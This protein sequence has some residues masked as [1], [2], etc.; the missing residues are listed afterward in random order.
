MSIADDVLCRQQ[1]VELKLARREN[2]GQ[3]E[4]VVAHEGGRH[5]P[6]PPNKTNKQPSRCR[7]GFSKI[8]MTG[9]FT[10]E[11]SMWSDAWT[12]DRRCSFGMRKKLTGAWNSR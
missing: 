10:P 6:T 5:P 1:K 11:S 2:A 3:L 7:I 4:G 9:G 8:G 12:L